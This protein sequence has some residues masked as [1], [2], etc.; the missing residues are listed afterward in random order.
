M[1]LSQCLDLDLGVRLQPGGAATVD[2]TLIMREP[3]FQAALAERLK[4]DPD[5]KLQTYFLS[6]NM[7]AV[8]GT[9]Q[10]FDN[11]LKDGLRRLEY[12]AEYPDLE[13]LVQQDLTGQMDLSRGNEAWTWEFGPDDLTTALAGLDDPTLQQALDLMAPELSGLKIRVQFEGVEPTSTTM[14][15]EDERVWVYQLDYDAVMSQPNGGSSVRRFRPL[16]KVARISF[17]PIKNPETESTETPV[18]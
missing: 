18:P 17:A 16:L 11:Q 2:M 5:L 1:G 8:G 12:R 6:R 10:H 7:E 13:T 3:L 4:R 15:Q 14:V 9:L